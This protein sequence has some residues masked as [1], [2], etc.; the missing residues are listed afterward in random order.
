MVILNQYSPSKFAQV[1]IA[2]LLI[3]YYMENHLFHEAELN[4]EFYKYSEI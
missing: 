4:F 1:Y 2:F 3:L